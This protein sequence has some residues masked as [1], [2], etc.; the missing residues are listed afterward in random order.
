[1]HL[2]DASSS[3]TTA[4]EIFGTLAYIPPEQARGETDRM[5][6]RGDVFSWA[7]F[8]AR[9]SQDSLLFLARWRLAK[10]RPVKGDFRR[11]RV[12]RSLRS[13]PA[14]VLLTKHLLDG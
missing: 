14:L 4:G 8:C 10:S 12:A 2:D 9:S 5:D 13:G 1:M 6:R 3:L 11:L 7:Q